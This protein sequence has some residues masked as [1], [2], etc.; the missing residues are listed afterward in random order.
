MGRAASALVSVGSSSDQESER[1]RKYRWTGFMYPDEHVK[2]KVSG[3]NED[4]NYQTTAHIQ[5]RPT[6][7][8]LL[9]L[10]LPCI[11][12]QEQFLSSSLDATKHIDTVSKA[13]S[14]GHIMG[15][16]HGKLE[17]GERQ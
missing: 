4:N 16:R 17:V 8:V 6:K 7:H 5:E 14:K 3:C 11:V 15:Q 2:F 9:G 12:L 1:E 13:C 10:T